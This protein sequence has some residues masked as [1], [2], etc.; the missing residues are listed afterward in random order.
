MATVYLKHLESLIECCLH[1]EACMLIWHASFE[2]YERV[3]VRCGR[4]G[5]SPF[6]CLLQLRRLRCTHTLQL[7]RGW[8]NRDAGDPTLKYPLVFL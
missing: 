5:Y 8:Y 4:Y 2:S 6:S 3:R 1:I 7:F